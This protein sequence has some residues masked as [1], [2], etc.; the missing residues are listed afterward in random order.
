VLSTEGKSADEIKAQARAALA[1]LFAAQDR[2]AET[3]S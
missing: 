3:D 1:G 2:D